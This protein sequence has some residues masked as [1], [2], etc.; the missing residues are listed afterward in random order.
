MSP[1]RLWEVRA[2]LTMLTDRSV[3]AHY[4]PLSTGKASDVVEDAVFTDLQ[5]KP[6]SPNSN[7]TTTLALTQPQNRQHRRIA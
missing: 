4:R 2:A 7:V 1:K 6:S 3:I 5:G